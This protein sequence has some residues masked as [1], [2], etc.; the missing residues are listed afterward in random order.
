MIEKSFFQVKLCEKLQTLEEIA[1]N[2]YNKL[3]SVV[4]QSDDA[5]FEYTS[6]AEHW[7]KGARATM[8]AALRAAQ[9]ATNKQ[10]E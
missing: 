3:K 8:L 5:Q 4:R 9:T 2:R 7:L 1:K 10:G 6:E